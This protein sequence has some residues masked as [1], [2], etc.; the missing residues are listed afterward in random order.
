MFLVNNYFFLDLNT[1]P[2]HT[3]LDSQACKDWLFSYFR[4][5]RTMI[6]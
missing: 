1:I 6:D 4:F 5:P 2:V 3:Y